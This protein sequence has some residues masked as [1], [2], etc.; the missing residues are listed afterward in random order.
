MVAKDSELRGR[1]A[2]AGVGCGR[3]RWF[4]RWPKRA[5]LRPDPDRIVGNVV[6]FPGG[7]HG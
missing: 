4:R 2:S 6:I 5:A 1:H 3:V 7:E